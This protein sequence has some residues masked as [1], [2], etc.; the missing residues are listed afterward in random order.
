MG[1][2]PGHRPFVYGKVERVDAEFIADVARPGI[3]P[4]CRPSDLT[5]TAKP[6]ASIS[7]GV[8]VAIADALKA[9]KLIF[10]HDPRRDNETRP[11]DSPTAGCGSGH[12]AIQ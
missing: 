5:A 12:F 4:S 3:V 1:I 2:N 11:I 10:N 7:D 8:A 6:I 9:T